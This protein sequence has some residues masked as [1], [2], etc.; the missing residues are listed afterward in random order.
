MNFSS[1]SKKN[2][3]LSNG[4]TDFVSVKACFGRGF[5]DEIFL[6]GLLFGRYNLDEADM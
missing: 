6:F 2:D 4:F 1:C 3:F 5:V